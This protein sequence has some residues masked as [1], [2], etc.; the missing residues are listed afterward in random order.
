MAW[1][2]MVPFDK[3]GNMMTYAE[4]SSGFYAAKEWRPAEKFS[5]KLTYRGCYR[6]RSA[7]VFTFVDENGHSYPFFMSGF[8]EIVKHMVNGVVSGIFQPVKRGSNYGIE[9]VG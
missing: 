8:D 1:N 4:G 6:G 5:A 3:D 7:A 2:K 9:K